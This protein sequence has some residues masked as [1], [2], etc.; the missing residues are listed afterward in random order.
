MYAVVL[1]PPLP[2]PPP[3]DSNVMKLAPLDQY[4]GLHHAQRGDAQNP[5]GIEIPPFAAPVTWHLKMTNPQ[6]GNLQQDPAS[7]DMEVR[8]VFL[9]L[10]YEWE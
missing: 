6:N 5:L 4:G 10:G 8:E 3:V 7:G 2:A 9:I 1:D